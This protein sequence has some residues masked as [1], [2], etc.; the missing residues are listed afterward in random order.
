MKTLSVAL[1]ACSLFLAGSTGVVMADPVG[2]EI[3]K[4]DNVKAH[5]TDIWTVRLYGDETTRIRL[6]GDGDTCLEL[7]VYDENGNLVASDTYGY[8]DDRQVVIRPYW[9]GSFRIKI[10]NLGSVSNNYVLV[11]D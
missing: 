3:V 2:G 10:R 6:S 11:V 7:R 9:T 4:V 1:V 5:H 8:G